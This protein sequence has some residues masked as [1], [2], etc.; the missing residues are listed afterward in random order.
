MPGRHPIRRDHLP[1]RRGP[2]GRFLVIGQREGT[3]LARP[4]AIDAVLVE[5]PRDLFREGHGAGL[6]GLPHPSDQATCRLGERLADRLVGQQFVERLPQIVVLGLGP[7]VP[8]AVL[9]VDP[10]AVAHHP[11]LIQDKR[12][13]RS[14]GAELV[15]HHGPGILEQREFNIVFARVGGQ[16]SN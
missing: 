11:L 7:H 14:L 6:V 13:G 8:N 9:V 5:D 16:I 1:D 3:N 2:A 10:P 4:M 12:L 15:G